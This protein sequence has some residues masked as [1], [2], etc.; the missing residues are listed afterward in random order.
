MSFSYQLGAN[1]NVDYPRMLFGDTVDADHIF[2][3]QEILSFTAIVGSV[4]QSGQRYSGGMGATLPSNPV[5]YLRVAAMMCDALASSKSR[6]ELTKLQDAT[7]D[8]HATAKGLR[9][10]ANQW[11]KV[12]DESG[13]F[14]I[15]EQCHTAFD[16][17]DRFIK[18]IQRQSL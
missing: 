7:V 11:R 15:I 9:D 8:F 3:D 10:Q 13:A 14:A 5:S 4:W 6:L 1:P 18:Q 2:E 12:D 16:Y 17:R